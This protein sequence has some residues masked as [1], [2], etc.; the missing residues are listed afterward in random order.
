[1]I[2]ELM[3]LVKIRNVG[4][5]ENISRQQLK[6]IFTTPS[7]PT[8]TPRKSFI[9]APSPKK[10]TLIPKKLILAQRPKISK[11]SI[12]TPKPKKQISKDY[13]PKKIADA[14]DDN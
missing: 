13:K 14:F 4:G 12:P 7:A 6:I 10:P 3:I 5:Y 2:E 1:M 8:P 9:P 11:K